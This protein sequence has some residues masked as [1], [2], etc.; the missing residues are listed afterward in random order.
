MRYKTCNQEYEYQSSSLEPLNRLMEYWVLIFIGIVLVMAELLR[1]LNRSRRRRKTSH[2]AAG[3]GHIMPTPAGINYSLAPRHPEVMAGALFDLLSQI[4]N[5]E[6]LSAFANLVAS[7]EMTD[8]YI[9]R[10][11]PR[12]STAKIARQLAFLCDSMKTN[13]F[14]EHDRGVVS[15][16][17]QRKADKEYKLL[18]IHKNIDKIF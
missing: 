12:K 1:W 17:F 18:Q 5:Y 10:L 3:S 6:Q 9:E 4:L 7:P 14:T 8:R 2:P 11:A 13:G 15:T 16:A